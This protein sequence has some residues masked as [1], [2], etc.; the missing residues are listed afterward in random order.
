MASWKRLYHC[1]TFSFM[2]QIGTV[3]VLSLNISPLDNLSNTKIP[4]LFLDSASIEQYDSWL[5]TG[6][7]A[8]VTTNPLILQQDGVSCTLK[9]ISSLIQHAIKKY[10]MQVF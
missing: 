7:F 5:S 2:I 1:L 10:D 4:R 3:E 6:L 8:G 9:A